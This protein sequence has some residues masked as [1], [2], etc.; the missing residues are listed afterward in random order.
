[1][2]TTVESFVVVLGS[3]VLPGRET[4]FQKG[5]GAL[6]LV[7]MGSA[8]VVFVVKVW[9]TPRAARLRRVV[10]LIVFVCVYSTYIVSVEMTSAIDVL[11]DRLLS[12]LYVPLLVLATSA[13]DG[14]VLAAPA[15][16][17]GLGLAVFGLAVAVLLVGEAWASAKEV[18]TAANAGVGLA[19]RS[20]Q[21]SPLA[22]AAARLPEG[23]AIF[24]ND[25]WALW[26]ATGR[27]P[28]LI[29]PRTH[30][31]RSSDRLS[32]VTPF[33]RIARCRPTY[34]VWY[35]ERNPV[36]IVKKRDLQRRV[37][38]VA[39]RSFADGT[40]SV[41]EAPESEGARCD[42]GSRGSLGVSLRSEPSP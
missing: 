38:L 30:P 1:L 17:R 4:S 20:V 21:M 24:S 25:P 41:V 29:S 37:R 31:H 39:E 28:L 36:Y 22:S 6:F 14:V 12:P 13:I 40:I 26:A 10:P 2:Q 16:L 23:S 8:F 15:R 33:V 9:R 3:W 19:H 5:A 27:E 35:P 18:R 42:K 32:E 34:L 11:N 7:L